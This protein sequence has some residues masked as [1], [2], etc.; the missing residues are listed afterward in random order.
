[1]VCRRRWRLL[2]VMAGLLV[3]A[4]AQAAVP[5]VPK[6][7]ADME[8]VHGQDAVNVRMKVIQDAPPMSAVLDRDIYGGNVVKIFVTTPPDELNSKNA[9]AR[10]NT[11]IMIAQLQTLS[12]DSA[13]TGMLTN[14]DPAIRYWGAKGLSDIAPFV[15]M[16]APGSVIAA[17]DAAA[18]VEKSSVVQQELVNALVLYEGKVETIDALDSMAGTMQSSLPDKPALEAATGG[19]LFVDASIKSL[20]APDKAHAVKVAAQLASFAAQ[21]QAALKKTLDAAGTPLPAGYSADIGKLADA[22]VKLINDA[23]G[24]K[25]PLPDPKLAPDDLLKTLNSI[26]GT[27]TTPGTLQSAAAD[28]PIP[29]AISTEKYPPPTPIPPPIPG[30][31]S[32]CSPAGRARFSGGGGAGDENGIIV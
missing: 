32:P 11:A 18:K 15:K 8:A 6:T 16:A 14:A 24:Q 23:T 28:A 1:M 3:P 29:P 2:M 25:I 26:V 5:P 9:D 30:P 27:G 17:L 10:L 21:H 12:T 22:A 13:L 20:A 31:Q 4:M 19:L 7:A